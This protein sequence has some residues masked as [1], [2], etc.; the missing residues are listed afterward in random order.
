MSKVNPTVKKSGA[1]SKM[2]DT[3]LAGGSG[4]KAAKQDN[5]SLLRRLTLANLLWEDN[6]YMN[7]DTI[8]NH[9]KTVLPL[10]DPAEVSKLTLEARIVQKLR[11]TPLFL[12][13]TMLKSPDHKDMVKDLLPKIITRPD[14][15]TDFLAIYQRENG[16]LKPLA[17]A[18]KK[19]L[20]NSFDNFSEYQFAKYDRDGAIKLR[21][22]LFL[23][24]AKPKQGKEELYKKIAD[25]TLSIPDTWEVALSSGADKKAT[26]ERLLEEKKLGALAFL[27]NLRNMMLAG[28]DSKIIKKAFQNMSS[29]MLLPLNFFSAAMY[30]P[31]FK[32][33]I[34]DMMLKTYANLPKLPGYSVFVVDVSGSMSANTSSNSKWTRMQAAMAMATLANELC[35]SVDIYCTA[36]S[37]DTRIHQTIQIEYPSHGFELT[38]QIQQIY[39]KLGGGGIFTRQ[40]LE[41]I[42][43]KVKT[44]PDR[45]M[46][47]SD[48]QDCDV[49]NSIPKPFG[50]NNY[51]V[52]VA[53]HRN[54]VNYKG[55][56]TAEL[57]G[58]SENFLTY[59]AAL[60]GVENKF[61]DID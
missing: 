38:N 54:G 42:E 13:V 33:D 14:M 46:I 52:D 1:S 12:A 53:A 25:R 61:E 27:R 39:N 18:A 17:S 23:T 22:A 7:G 31:E 55:V 2:I 60:E 19:G 21:D 41:F 37:D 58:F 4:I 8:S 59:I 57:S 3:R 51:I 5:L 44:Q 43:K 40:C 36:G 34:N 11:H 16:H 32:H 30:A 35:E 56:W 29:Q 45:I 48:S 10:C 47:F 50:K 49:S 28:V 6:A 15:I 24:H 26:W 20:A 9:I